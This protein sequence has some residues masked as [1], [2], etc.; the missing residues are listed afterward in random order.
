[1]DE[2]TQGRRA[3]CDCP[4]ATAQARGF[5][6]RAFLRRSGVVAGAVGLMGGRDLATR[7]AFAAAPYTGDVVVV[8]SFRGGMDGLSAVVPRGDADFAAARPN[9]RVPDRCCSG[10]ARWP[11]ATTTGSACTRRWPR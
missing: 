11:T 10:S 8:V 6:R 9:I 1:M 5:T 4:D 7:L 3:A 2:Q